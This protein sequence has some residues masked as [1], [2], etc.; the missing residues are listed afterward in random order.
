MEEEGIRPENLW[1]MDESG[2]MIGC[3]RGGWIWTYKEID[4]PIIDDLDERTLVT[5]IEAISAS[6]YVIPP[7]VIVPRVNLPSK[8]F[9]NNLD[10]DT[11]LRASPNGY[12]DD[13]IAL[14]WLKHFNTHS[15]PLDKNQKRLLLLDG[16]DSHTTFEF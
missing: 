5:A 7:F 16:H 11:L 15:I 9:Y 13:Q 2:F 12:T 4:K 3:L 6:G 10:V 1:N 14:E 8:F